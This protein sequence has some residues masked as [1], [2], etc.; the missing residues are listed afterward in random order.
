VTARLTFTIPRNLWLTANRAPHNRGWRARQV[1]DL[2]AIARNEASGLKPID[3]PVHADW[4]VR[5][6]KGVR[7]D[8]GDAANAQPTTKALL[9]GLVP[10]VL[11]DDGPLHVISETFR[12]GPNLDRPSDHE[13]TLLLV[14]E[15]P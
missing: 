6:P 9:D 12:R 10:H 2:Q 4:T 15:T 7:R 13:V 5:Y 11:A 8:K 3:G 14:K 1:A